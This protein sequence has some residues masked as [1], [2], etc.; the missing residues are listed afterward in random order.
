MSGTTKIAIGVAVGLGIPLIGTL[1][2]IAWFLHK[3]Y[4]R[5]SQQNQKMSAQTVAKHNDV[6]EKDP[7]VYTDRVLEPQEMSGN[8]HLRFEQGPAELQS[9]R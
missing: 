2:A 1:A 5:K 4:K 3:S 8:S 7:P 9:D 6:V